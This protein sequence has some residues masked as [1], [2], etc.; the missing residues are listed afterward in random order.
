MKVGQEKLAVFSRML[1]PVG[2]DGTKALFGLL[3][4][5]LHQE[6]DC[7]DEASEPIDTRRFR[8]VDELTSLQHFIC[9]IEVSR[10]NL[11]DCQLFD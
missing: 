6:D 4:F 2:F 1:E 11:D 10:L 9:L 8:R 7:F 5:S 3:K